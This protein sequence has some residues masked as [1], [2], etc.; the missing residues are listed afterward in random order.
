M[1]NFKKTAFIR[2]TNKFVV[3]K[4]RRDTVI[5]FL[6]VFSWNDTKC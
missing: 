3:F 5:Y 1:L 2:K 6:K 4:V